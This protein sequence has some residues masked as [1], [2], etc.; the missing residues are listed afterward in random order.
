[1]SPAKC[2]DGPPHKLKQLPISCNFDENGF[3]SFSVKKFSHFGIA[4][5]EFTC[6]CKAFYHKKNSK[7]YE[8]EVALMKQDW[9]DHIGLQPRLQAIV[10]YYARH[11]GDN[12]DDKI[13]DVHFDDGCEEITIHIS[14]VSDGWEVQGESDVKIKAE[15]LLQFDPCNLSFNQP[16]SCKFDI[17]WKDAQYPQ[18]SR[19]PRKVSLIG[20]IDTKYFNLYIPPGILYSITHQPDTL[21]FFLL[22]IT[23]SANH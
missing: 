17:T 13:E 8:M 21:R 7:H 6:L 11:F 23:I 9:F 10:N 4:S 14:D 5:T 1:M 15:D 12:K 2:S 3:A 19:S 20:S 16:P 22:N 18:E